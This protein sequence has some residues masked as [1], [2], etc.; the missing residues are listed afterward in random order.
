MYVEV[1]LRQAPIVQTGRTHVSAEARSP[2]CK[3]GTRGR[4]QTYDL[5]LRR[6]L[7]LFTELLGH[8]AEALGF[9]PRD[10]SSPSVVFKTTALN[11]STKPPY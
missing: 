3:Y 6:R 4:I 5:P 1:G 7:L 11:H 10:G 8:M 9:E 2:Q